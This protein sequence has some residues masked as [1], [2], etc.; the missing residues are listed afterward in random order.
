MNLQSKRLTRDQLKRIVERERAAGRRIVFTNGCFDLL[1][2][3]HVRYLDAARRL[4]D[5]LV[6][7][8]NAD[9]TVRQLK[10]EGRPMLALEARMRIL[11]ALDAVDY[12]VA[13]EEPT[14]CDL[15]RELRPEV[16]VKG[17]DYGIEGVV[18]REIVEA[19][20]GTVCVVPATPGISTTHTVTQMRGK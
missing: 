19:Y 14:P 13:F 2:V 15:L 1:H 4:G 12:V 17:G 16:L 6:V 20:G 3:G 9:E 11:S 10:G 5:V 8:V 18:G 7:A